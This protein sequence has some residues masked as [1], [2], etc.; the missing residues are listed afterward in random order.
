MK[1]LRAKSVVCDTSGLLRLNVLKKMQSRSGGYATRG[2]RRMDSGMVLR[3]R[4]EVLFG[5]EY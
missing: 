1:F 4:K 2:R 3:N 5:S